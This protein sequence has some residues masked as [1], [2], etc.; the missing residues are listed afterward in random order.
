MSQH[1]QPM[2]STTPVDHQCT[3]KK[4]A[5]IRHVP[6]HI[7]QTHPKLF[8]EQDFVKR[9]A[10]PK[11]TSMVGSCSKNPFVENNI[12][13]IYLICI[14]KNI[15]LVGATALLTITNDAI[16]GAFYNLSLKVI[17]IR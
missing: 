14:K 15:F 1:L 16:I 7:G 3:A 8:G 12:L 2:S 5:E 9:P 6:K 13:H 10:L 11:K 4:R 17:S